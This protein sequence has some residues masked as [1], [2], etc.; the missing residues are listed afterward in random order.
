VADFVALAATAARL[1]AENGRTITLQQLGNTPAD[2]AKPWRGPADP[3]SPVRASVTGPAVFAA[4]KVRQSIVW[5]LAQ[6]FNDG[7]KNPAQVCLFA[8][9]ND[10]GLDLT[11]FDQI[12]DGT[13]TWRIM[14]AELLQP[15]DT[16]I[17][18]AFEVTR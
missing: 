15:A 16:K 10:D 13:T 12:V 7:V 9:T 3:E 14:R 1:I 8:A 2:S 4:D 17:L 11:Q 18:Y 5:S 6:S